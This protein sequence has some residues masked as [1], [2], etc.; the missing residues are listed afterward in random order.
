MNSRT[1]MWQKAAGMAAATSLVAAA[2]TLFTWAVSP[3]PSEP[4]A[5]GLPDIPSRVAFMSGPDLDGDGWADTVRH[6]P[7]GLTVTAATGAV[8]LRLQSPVSGG[9]QVVNL[10]GEYP[11]L[12]AEVEPGEYAAFAFAPGTG[13]LQAVTWPDGQMRGHGELTPDGALHQRLAGGTVRR[14]T[15]LLALEKLRLRAVRTVTEPLT[16]A[17]A[18]PSET[19]AAAV[20]AAALGL[21]S[22]MVVHFAEEADGMAFYRRWHGSLPA[23]TARVA[24]A[25]DVDAGAVHGHQV[26][27]TVWVTGPDNVA[28]L[29][30]EVAFVPPDPGSPAR[31][32]HLSL[33]P[34]PLQVDSWAEA[35]RRLREVRP[36]L[37]L[38]HRAESPFYGRF[39]LEAHGYRYTVD[40][41]TGEVEEQ[42]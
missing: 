15:L 42:G 21:R 32:R 11:V 24:L 20:E 22:E 6:G 7:G 41:V 19:L 16:R 2:L 3:P 35:K 34:V 13:L 28:G 9:V 1:P 12:F 37:G 27:I 36:W 39:R 17:P 40:A 4:D 38:I 33:E 10:G 29:R 26:P 14:R 8:L 25:G 23:G 30:G 5:A 31:I 18:R